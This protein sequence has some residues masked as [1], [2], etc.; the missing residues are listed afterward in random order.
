MVELMISSSL[1]GLLLTTPTSIHLITHPHPYIRSLTHIHPSNYSPTFIHLITHPHPYIRSLTHIHP[2][3]HLPT[4]IHLITHQ[5]YST[6]SSLLSLGSWKEES[7]MEKLIH[8]NTDRHNPHPHPHAA[9]TNSG[10]DDKR[11]PHQLFNDKLPVPHSSNQQTQP[12]YHG[13]VASIP[14]T[15]RHDPASPPMEIPDNAAR[16]SQGQGQGHSHSQG[17]GQGHSHSHSHSQGQS[18]SSDKYLDFSAPFNRSKAG[19]PIISQLTQA[20]SSYG[21]G[22]GGGGGHTSHSHSESN[23]YSSGGS[24]QSTP[25]FTLQQHLN[26]V[27]HSLLSIH[28]IAL[29]LLYLHVHISPQPHLLSIM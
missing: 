3:N 16:H 19:Q 1:Y 17:Q 26:M 20:I 7:P 29:L 4:F 2:S 13:R 21:G 22:G 10:D 11:S 9:Y 15:L 18:P 14:P 6:S 23:S 25:P 28:N 27:A 12:H 24:L 8:Q 5:Y